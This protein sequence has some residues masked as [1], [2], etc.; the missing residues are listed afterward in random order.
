KRQLAEAGPDAAIDRLCKTLRDAKDYAKLFYA[1]LMRKRV[2]MGV[3]PIPTAGATELTPAQQEEYEDAIPFSCP[4]VG[5]QALAEGNIPYAF[6]FFRMIGELQPV[7]EAIEKYEPGPDDDVQPVIDVAYQQA[8]HPKKGFDLV[9]DR[10]GICSA[11]TTASGLD[12]S[13]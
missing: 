10:Y 3:S 13:L 2:A 5:G 7:R 6:N 9:L 4:G 11:I 12:P 1:M 8:V